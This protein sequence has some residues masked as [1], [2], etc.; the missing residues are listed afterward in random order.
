MAKAARVLYWS[1]D[2]ASQGI[3]QELLRALRE[4]ANP[5]AGVDVEV[6]EVDKS[7]LHLDRRDL[8]KLGISPLEHIVVLSKHSSE[9]GKPSLTVHPTGNPGP[10]AALGGSPSKLSTATPVLMSLIVRRLTIE[11]SQA[12]VTN[13]Y[14][15]LEATHH[16]PTELENPI[17]FVEIGS[18]PDQWSRTDL[19]RVVAN[20]VLGALRDFASLAEPPCSVAASFGENHYPARLTR[21]VV[22]GGICVGHVIP[23]YALR[24]ISEEVLLQAM[25]KSQPPPS[26][27]LIEKKSVPRE[28]E[29]LIELRAKERGLSVQR[30]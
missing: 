11:A 4:G 13:V 14:V 25:T 16:G 26:L 22:E 8:D 1:G 6:T 15:G 17:C 19:H 29:R 12:G 5:L 21:R 3:S 2:P 20:A 30:Y 27:V 10:T 28:V 23:R 9:S 24:E 7:P 18:S